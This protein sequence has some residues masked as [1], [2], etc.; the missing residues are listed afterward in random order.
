MFCETRRDCILC[1]DSLLNCIL[2]TDRLLNCILCTDSLLNCILCT[3]SLLN[4][5]FC[6]D[7]SLNSA[8]PYY[9]IYYNTIMLVVWV[10]RKYLGKDFCVLLI[11]WE[12]WYRL[13][14]ICRDIH[15]KPP[16]Q[17]LSNHFSINW[18]GWLHNWGEKKQ[19]LNTAKHYWKGSTKCCIFKYA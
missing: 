8:V 19:T 14:N 11:I 5:I 4:C 17:S 1:R 6:T 18:F 10:I 12:N 15:L 3:D 7:S 13:L 9:E 2:C 16:A